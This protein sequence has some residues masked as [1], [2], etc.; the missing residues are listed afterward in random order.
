MLRIWIDRHTT[1]L[2]SIQLQGRLIVTVVFSDGYSAQFLLVDV[3]AS[4]CC[5]FIPGSVRDPDG[6][7]V[8]DNGEPLANSEPVEVEQ[9][10]WNPGP[11]PGL[12]SDVQVVGLLGRGWSVTVTG[13]GGPPV[14]RRY[15][16]Y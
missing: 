4:Q 1:T 2:Q 3:R 5:T 10:P 12:F 14:T 7:P 6:N 16:G 9:D 11:L 8:Q 15:L 13:G